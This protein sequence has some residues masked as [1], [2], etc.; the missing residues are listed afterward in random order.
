MVTSSWREAR[1]SNRKKILF[2]LLSDQ[3]SLLAAAQQGELSSIES[4][5][6][7]CEPSI[8][9]NLD[10]W[11][12]SFFSEVLSCL[13]ISQ[14][15]PRP[16][17]NRRNSGTR[18]TFKQFFIKVLK[19]GDRKEVYRLWKCQRQVR[20]ELQDRPGNKVTAYCLF[21]NKWFSAP[22]SASM[23]VRKK[24]LICGARSRTKSLQ[25]TLSLMFSAQQRWY[26]CE[27]SFL[28]LLW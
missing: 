19:D 4:L 15:G 9:I 11:N 1:R 24:L 8:I 18:C 3:V 26:L 10:I 16:K 5:L 13:T 7:F 17:H 12:S 25:G 21:H 6:Q 2:R 23:S 27:Q 22:S 20:G 14:D 28:S